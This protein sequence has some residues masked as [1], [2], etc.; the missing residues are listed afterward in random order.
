MAYHIDAAK[1]L[2]W[3]NQSAQMEIKTEV[4]VYIKGNKGTVFAVEG[5]LYCNNAQE[6]FIAV[7]ELKS[8]LTSGF[9]SEYYSKII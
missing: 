9:K 8:R 3:D 4:L 7:Q 5:P 1:V 6:V 2:I